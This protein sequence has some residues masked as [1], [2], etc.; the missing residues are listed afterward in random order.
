MANT[1][2]NRLLL[3]LEQV[4]ELLR[5][6][7]YSIRSEQQYLNWIRRFVI[8]NG[9]RHPLEL[10]AAQLHAFLTHLAVH[11]KVA[12]STRARFCSCTGRLCDRIYLAWAMSFRPKTPQRL[13]VVLTVEETKAVMAKLTGVHLPRAQ[14]THTSL[15]HLASG[16]PVS[17]FVGST[18]PGGNI[19]RFTR[20]PSRSKTPTATTVRVPSLQLAT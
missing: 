18:A 13:P 15:S 20:L 11:G 8:F 3:L 5:V 9:N 10:G 6:K 1:A 19:M 17:G 16:D 2:P 14:F 4:K 12:A 7:R